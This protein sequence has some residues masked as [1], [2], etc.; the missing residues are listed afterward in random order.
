MIN[1]SLNS[2][3]DPLKAAQINFYTIVTVALGKSGQNIF[4]NFSFNFIR[5][6][7]SWRFLSPKKAEIW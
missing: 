3:L 4:S 5:L 2:F 7:T 6:N 1:F